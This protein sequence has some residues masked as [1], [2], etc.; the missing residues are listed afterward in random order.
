MNFKTLSE[1]MSNCP[2]HI[3]VSLFPFTRLTISNFTQFYFIIKLNGKITK[4]LNFEDCKSGMKV[5][6]FCFFF[7]CEDC[8]HSTSVAWWMYH[9]RGLRDEFSE[10]PVNVVRDSSDVFLY[11]CDAAVANMN[12]DSSHELRSFSI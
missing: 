4:L 5:F 1:F 7:S 10:K 2:R 8:T 11:R 12:E 3:Q 6:L 9:V